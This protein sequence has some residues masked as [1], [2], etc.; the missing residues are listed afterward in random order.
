MEPIHSMSMTFWNGDVGSC[1]LQNQIPRKRKL[2]SIQSSGVGNKKKD[3][4]KLL[5]SKAS[6]L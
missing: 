1:D 6:I 2:A 3:T 4:P 5:I